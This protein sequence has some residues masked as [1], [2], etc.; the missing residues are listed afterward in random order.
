MQ[1]RRA[2]PRLTLGESLR[3][4]AAKLKGM[5]NKV[6]ES[7]QDTHA[8]SAKANNQS[9]L[10]MARSMFGSGPADL[11]PIASAAALAP[12][13]QAP[14][15]TVKPPVPVQQQQA[16]PLPTHKPPR[17]ALA[18]LPTVKPEVPAQPV[19]EGPA[20]EKQALAGDA[21]LDEIDKI[22]QGKLWSDEDRAGAQNQAILMAGL[23][24]MEAGGQPGA[25]FLGTVGSGGKAGLAD[26]A[27]SKEQAQKEAALKQNMA[28]DVAAAKERA[29]SNAETKRANMAREEI[30]RQENEIRRTQ[31]SAAASARRDEGNFY[32]E[33]Y[34]KANPDA[35]DGEVAEYT[36][37][38]LTNRKGRTPEDLRLEAV[39]V[40]RDGIGGMAFDSLS[41]AEK[42]RQISETVSLI[43]GVPKKSGPGLKVGTVDGGYRYNGGDPN[44]QNNWT[45]V[46]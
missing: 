14:L 39:K 32:G 38:A 36:L 9:Q 43:A 30:L 7:A 35:S 6:V 37:D 45:R 28:L 21:Y 29:G 22:M 5:F 33:L 40:L 31:G 23:G 16:A 25:S 17:P 20:N 3:R 10:A 1:T 26:Y 34:R 15:P 4:D 12:V 41:P 11:S 8:N 24:M 18:P 27:G 13:T 2:I 19:Q 42:E 46:D 44:D